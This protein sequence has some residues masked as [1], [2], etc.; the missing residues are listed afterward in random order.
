MSQSKLLKFLISGLTQLA[1]RSLSV[2]RHCLTFAPTPSTPHPPQ[3]NPTADT[4]EPTP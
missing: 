1:Q 3:H 4:S 2:L